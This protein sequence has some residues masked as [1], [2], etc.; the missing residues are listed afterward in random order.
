MCRKSIG[1]AFLALCLGALDIGAS[2]TADLIVRGETLL[3][4]TGEAARTTG[5]RGGRVA[6]RQGE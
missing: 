1:I 2:Q 6:L 4:G 3:D 5:R